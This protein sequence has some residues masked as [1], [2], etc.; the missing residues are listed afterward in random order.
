MPM[1]GIIRPQSRHACAAQNEEVRQ[2]LFPASLLFSAIA[3]SLLILQFAPA[4]F[5]WMLLTWAA[6][7]WAAMF[8]CPRVLAP[9]NPAQPRN[10]GMH[11]G[12][13]S[14]HTCSPMNT[15]PG[16]FRLVSWFPMTYWDG[17]LRRGCR[18]RLWKSPPGTV[19]PPRWKDVRY[20]VHDRLERA[21]HRSPIQQGRFGRHGPVLRLLIHFRR[22]PQG[23]RNIAIPGW[24]PVGRAVPYL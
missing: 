16:F 18:L 13:R 6:A 9:R 5:F 12:R 22:R 11:A 4:P 8:V 23:R 19:P 15:H 20:R 17:P 3:A 24:R 7:L 10:R 14:R 2:F 1:T 21:S